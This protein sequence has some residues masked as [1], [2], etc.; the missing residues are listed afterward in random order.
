M[1]LR[2]TFD[3]VDADD[4]RGLRVALRRWLVRALNQMPQSL[5][6]AE[7]RS[8]LWRCLPAQVKSS[9][10]VLWLGHEIGR[11]LGSLAREGLIS[12]STESGRGVWGGPTISAPLLKPPQSTSAV[13]LG[14]QSALPLEGQ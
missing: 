6:L 4:L 7:I 11:S 3:E 13:P 8:E 5:T 1:V 14:M 12:H 10:N 9:P 2:I